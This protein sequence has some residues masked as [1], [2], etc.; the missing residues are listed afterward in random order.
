MGEPA[1]SMPA[2]IRLNII[3]ADD[4]PL[5][6]SSLLIITT[7]CLL[8]SKV[9]KR[10][11][12]STGEGRRTERTVSTITTKTTRHLSQPTPAIN[13]VANGDSTEEPQKLSLNLH[14][15]PCMTLRGWTVK[16]WLRPIPL[17]NSDRI[18]GSIKNDLA[19]G[20]PFY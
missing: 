9:R 16:P 2:L 11:S 12:G 10:R 17:F 19:G 1:S 13:A 5:S 14:G 4:H 18:K 15:D 8:F 3:D 20:T 6:L 7:W